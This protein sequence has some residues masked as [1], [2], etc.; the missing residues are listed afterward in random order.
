MRGIALCDFNEQTTKGAGTTQ[1][2]QPIVIM[3]NTEFGAAH[4]DGT[5]AARQGRS[6]CGEAVEIHF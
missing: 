5:R 1:R 6:L 3:A 4:L 2:E